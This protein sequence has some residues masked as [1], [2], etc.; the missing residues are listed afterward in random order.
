MF[1]SIASTCALRISQ[2]IVSVWEAKGVSR[3]FGV[4]IKFDLDLSV[5]AYSNSRERKLKAAGIRFL[6]L[7]YRGWG[8]QRSH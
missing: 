8:S 1:R 3:Q 2:G 7:L 5:F 4:I 6:S